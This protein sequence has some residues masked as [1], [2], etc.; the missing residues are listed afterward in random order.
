VPR[1]R[2]PAGHF[3]D[4]PRAEQAPAVKG[5]PK[6]IPATGADT[7][8]A[9]ISAVALLVAVPVAA[10]V[11]VHPGTPSVQ[12]QRARPVHL[13]TA[14]YAPCRWPPWGP[15]RELDRGLTGTSPSEVSNL[16]VPGAGNP[17]DLGKVR[18][19]KSVSWVTSTAPDASRRPFRRVAE[20]PNS[21]Q[22]RVQ[23]GTRRL[24]DLRQGQGL[25]SRS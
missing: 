24:K 17:C 12:G 19:V 3:T 2:R 20:R 7:S 25:W 6:G 8:T 16:R 11:A 9:T 4:C 1:W 23:S 14:R 5:Q 10:K 13:G 18:W 22:E 21:P 15:F